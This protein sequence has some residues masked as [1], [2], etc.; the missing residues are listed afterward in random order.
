MTRWNHQRYGTA[1]D[2][3]RQSDLNDVASQWGCPKKLQ[4]RKQAEAEGESTRGPNAYPGLVIGSAVHLTIET[5]LK[6]APER[7]FAGE[8]PSE[9][10]VAQL[11]EQYL[12]IAAEH[13][14]IVWPDTKDARAK[15]LSAAVAMVRGALEALPRYASEVLF[16]EP[17]FTLEL[18]SPNASQVFAARGTIDLVYRPR[19]DPDGLGLLDWKT[20]ATRLERE[21]LDRGYQFG[22]YAQALRAGVLGGHGQPIRVGRF[23]TEIYVVELRDFV[24]Y[25]R[26]VSRGKRIDRPEELAFYG[27]KLF[28]ETLAGGAEVLPGQGFQPDYEHP[29]FGPCLTLPP[30]HLVKPGKGDLRGPG[31]YQ[32]QRSEA[33]VDGLM[34]SVRNVVKGV[35]LGVFYQNIGSSCVKC[36]FRDPCRG[37]GYA[38]KA[39]NAPALARLADELELTGLEG[40]AV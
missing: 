14:P 27:A 35:R 34:E 1:E 17:P 36:A 25:E 13:R 28:E 19:H 38:T 30:G 39:S 8:V 12:P 7:I 21:K 20:G 10:A 26:A 33:D 37:D 16:V 18:E 11:I 24:P 40:F 5:Y 15:E 31:F 32:A 22:L 3:L 9:E 4:L 29:V 6:K 23:P 2:P